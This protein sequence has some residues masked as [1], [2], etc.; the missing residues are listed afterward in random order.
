MLLLAVVLA[1]FSFW[2]LFAE[3]LRPGIHQLPTNREAAFIAGKARKR[4]TWAASLGV[5]RGDLW[6]E[7][8]FTY[9]ILLW[10][11]SEQS[12][13][14]NE[15]QARSVIERA[16]AYAPYEPGL[17]LLAA[18][19]ASRFNWS[20]SNPAA[21]LKMSYY[22]GPNESYLTPLRLFTA[23]HSDVLSDSDIQRFVQRDVGMILTRWPQLRPALIT[24]YKDARPD[25]KKII[26]GSVIQTDARFLET[27]LAATK[28]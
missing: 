17:W 23:D 22:T 10:P 20:G 7:S 9:A 26:E 27:M 3:L 21:E 13:D 5:I 18:S 28:P 8:A 4:A 15:S 25:T 16:L 14:T 6:A 12:G 24:A 2:I 19:L 11:S 1:G